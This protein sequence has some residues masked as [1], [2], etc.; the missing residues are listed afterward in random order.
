[1]VD[2]ALVVA[3]LTA[4]SIARGLPSPV[5]DHGG[6]RVDSGLVTERARYVFIEPCEG[7][8]ALGEAI[9]E[10]RI[11]LKLCRPNE[12][13]FALLPDRWKLTGDADTRVMVRDGIPD[14]PFALPAGYRLESETHHPVT[15]VR[16]LHGEELAASGY[17]AE[18]GGV[19]IYDRI[20]TQDAHQRRGL[21]RALM[22]ALGAARRSVGGREI[23]TATP[24][25]RSLY[26]K[27]GW[28]NYSPY[29]TAM[30]PGA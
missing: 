3:W 20:V 7:L 13:L 6:W 4:R 21:G 9:H 11:A 16:I 26:L 18:H 27:L 19:F 15:R 28:R 29:S 24:A 30:I 22:A 25:G 10:P 1:M 5:A 23:L 17:A 8:R 12:E 2:G 14:R